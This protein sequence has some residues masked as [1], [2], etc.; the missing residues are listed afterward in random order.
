MFDY[1]IKRC[2]RVAA[3]KP[4]FRLLIRTRGHRS[5]PL[6]R[7]SDLYAYEFGGENRN[8]AET[9][10]RQFRPL[11]SVVDGR[12]PRDGWTPEIIF[13]IS[14]TVVTVRCWQFDGKARGIANET[15]NTLVV[16][17]RDTSV[18]DAVEPRERI[19]YV[20]LRPYFRVSEMQERK[21]K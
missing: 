10:A 1:C 20:Y 21:N 9:T 4:I 16:G 11:V 3:S 8:Q 14:S 15:R 19:I 6:P 5:P 17:T 18:E 7:Q 2:R 13:K 12:W